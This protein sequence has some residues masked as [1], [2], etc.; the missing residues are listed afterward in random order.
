MARTG[1]KSDASEPMLLDIIT[2]MLHR[3][4]KNR[5]KPLKRLVVYRNGCSEGDFD[6]VIASEAPIFLRALKDFGYTDAKLIIIVPDKF[7]NVRLVCF[8]LL[9]IVI[10]YCFSFRKKSTL[11]ISQTR[12]TLNRDTSSTPS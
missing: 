10:L 5:N 11:A 9:S 1:G 3:Y 6:K 8:C 2:T 12:K 4:K 7:H